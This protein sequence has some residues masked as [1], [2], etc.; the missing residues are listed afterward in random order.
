MVFW[1]PLANLIVYVDVRTATAH[2]F[3]LNQHKVKKP[4]KGMKPFN[5]DLTNTDPIPVT[6]TSASL[7]GSQAAPAKSGVMSSMSSFFGGSNKDQPNSPQ[8]KFLFNEQMT[9]KNLRPEVR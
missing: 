6:S 5:F 4:T 3:F 7:T 2:P 9:G 8:A 1:E